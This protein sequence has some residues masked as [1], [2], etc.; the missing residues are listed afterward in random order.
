MSAVG[1]E[2]VLVCGG[3]L[4]FFF[5]GTH[6]CDGKAS[7]GTAK[8]YCV[9]LYCHCV[10]ISFKVAFKSYRTMQQSRKLLHY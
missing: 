1:S 9:W 5:S 6:S 8:D 3:D 4:G 7:V 2:I 10:G